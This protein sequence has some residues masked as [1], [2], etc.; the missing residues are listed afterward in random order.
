MSIPAPPGAPKAAPAAP[1]AREGI[2]HAMRLSVEQI[3]AVQLAGQHDSG[4]AHR[5]SRCGVYRPV[6]GGTYVRRRDGGRDF[7]CKGCKRAPAP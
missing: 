7:V 1:K 4:K 2:A 6:R 3:R 5:C